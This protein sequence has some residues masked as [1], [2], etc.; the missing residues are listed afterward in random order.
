MN[1][2]S[3]S[4]IDFFG[5]FPKYKSQPGRKPGK[6]FFATLEKWFN[7]RASQLYAMKRILT[8]CLPILFVSKISFS[9]E[10]VH[11]CCDTLVCLPGTPVPLVVTI[12]S[13]TTGEL[14]SILDDT[15][16]QVVDIGFPFT[17]F[18]N[19]YSKC[20]LSTNAYITFDTTLALQYSPWPINESAPSVNNPLNAIYGPWHDVNPAVPPYGCMGFGTFGEE[21]NRFFVFT[22]YGVPYYLCT[23]TLFTGQIILYE[24][25]NEIEIHLVDKR[26]CFEWNSG[27]AIEGLQDATGSTAVIIPGRNYPTLWTAFDDAYRFTPSGNTYTYASI[28]CA[29][30]P[31]AAGTPVWFTTDGDYVGTGYNITVNPQETTSYMVTAGQCGSAGDTVTVS[32]GTVPAIYDTVDLS[33]IN[34]N[35]GAISVIPTDNSG[36]YTFVW[37]NANGDTIQINNG[38][39]GDTL[40]NLP[41]GTYEL[42]FLNSQGCWQEHSYT[43]TQPVYGASFTASPDL[44]CDGAA[45]SFTD[46]SFGNITNYSWSFGDGG[47][48]S[49]Q[50]PTH[51]Y[52]GPGTYTATL[53]VTVLPNCTATQSQTVIVHPNISGG[54]TADPPPFCVGDAVQFTD[55][56]IGN[57]GNWDWNFGDGGVSSEQNPVHVYDNGGTY[58]VSF[59]AID[60]FCG[61][62]QD[63]MSITAYTYPIP[64][65]QEDTTLCEGAIIFL[66]A[67]DTGDTYLWST[68]ETTSAIN[69]VMPADTLVFVWVSVGNNGCMG[70]DT[71]VLRNRCVVLLPAAFSPNGDGKNDLFHPLAANVTD[72]DFMVLNRWGQV[73]YADNSGDVARGWNG[74]F[75]GEKQPIG[76]YLYHITGH[77]VSGKPFVRKGNV[78]IVR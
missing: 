68:G 32:V 40:P 77:F 4:A 22:F 28:P 7:F 2:L 1:Q 19:T 71:V 56:T 58:T 18:G 55:N 27:A 34:S 9:Q 13:G 21:P 46:F 60:S 52:T 25:S 49:Q 76:V 51:T 50:N 24:G 11:A 37:T 26:I 63:S 23:D 74:E 33:C 35:D 36:P 54:F 70:F 48:S 72:Y 78:T 62:V 17:F 65:L 53:T 10:I 3:A 15:Y 61:T 29:P 5:K 39:A 67:N 20:I 43:V 16:S 75:N 66:A 57:P 41:A 38:S 31:I 14:L 8:L 12:D 42:S 59:T 44:I 45:V 6:Q 64:I 30:V 73:V 69:F 47:I